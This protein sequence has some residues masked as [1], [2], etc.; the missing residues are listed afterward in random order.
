MGG[1]RTPRR[2]PVDQNEENDGHR[3]KCRNRP[4]QFG[5]QR[6]TMMRP[7]PV[8]VLALFLGYTPFHDIKAKDTT[9]LDLR[10]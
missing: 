2:K 10:C 6:C 9:C 4:K 1:W 8:M 3:K 5:L 7:T